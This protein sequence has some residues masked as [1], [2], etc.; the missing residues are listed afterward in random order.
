MRWARERLEGRLSM[1]L[2]FGLMECS[3]CKVVMAALW[4]SHG[5]CFNGNDPG[6]G[7]FLL[8]SVRG[9]R[10]WLCQRLNGYKR[11]Q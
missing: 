6:D 10:V 3:R 1:G 4:T 9:F 2:P 11:A 8:Y 5:V 7:H